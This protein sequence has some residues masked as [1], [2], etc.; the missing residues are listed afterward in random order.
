[1]LVIP[2]LAAAL[3]G[4]FRSFPLTLIGGLVIGVLE[5]EIGWLQS[6]LTQHSGIR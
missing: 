2:A 4:G 6:Y 5:S 1:M 3:L